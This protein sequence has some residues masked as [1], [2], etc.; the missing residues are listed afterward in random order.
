MA[1]WLPIV[2]QIKSLVQV[3]G[4][5]AEG[6]RR[7]QENFSKQC[8]VVS[9]VRSAVE[10]IGG[11]EEAARKTQMEF[12][13]TVSG[14]ADS[15]PIVGHVKG[16]IH[17]ACGD[18]DGGDNA[19][20]AASRT[21]GAIVGGAGGLIV[22]GPVGAVAGGIAG[23]ATVD[24]I[25]TGIDSA[26][27]KEYRP[28]GYVDQVTKLVEDPKNPGTW[29]DTTFMVVG[30]G[31]TGKAGGKAS[32]Q[33]QKFAEQRN[34]RLKFE[35]ERQP[36]VEK[37]GKAAAKD[38]VEAAD[39]MKDVRNKFDVPE[40]RPHIT[41]V[42]RDL[43][44]HEVFEGHNKN[45]RDFCRR[46]RFQEQGRMSN[47]SNPNEPSY[48]QE[49]FNVQEP[50]PRD[51][52]T[53]AEHRAF[54]KYYKENPDRN[55]ANTRVA[56]VRYDRQA[57][58]IKAVNRCDNC[59][60]YNEAMGEVPGDMINNMNVP[61]HPGVGKFHHYR[62]AGMAAGYCAACALIQKQHEEEEEELALSEKKDVEKT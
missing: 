4:G 47:Y 13:H 41:S 49:R 42:V 50:L 59:V 7:T 61:N 34:V 27:H 10:A 26:V 52:K 1:D 29:F 30:D 5:D 24:G 38:M 31:L 32:K 16:G 18:T 51:G 25:T 56:T 11:D 55:A 22:G 45:V 2:S 60:A 14:V 39:R 62:K 23:A 21:T 46:E 36:I 28:A 3:I 35:A 19:M 37:V 58:A 40:N 12:V 6:A 33:M 43:E 9:Q 48:V 57:G 44:T 17:Y 15:L 8:P 20:K 54:H 53:C